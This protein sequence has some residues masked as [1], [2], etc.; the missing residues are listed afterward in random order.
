MKM[1]C[2][3]GHNDPFMCAPGVKA[4]ARSSP[5]SI[6]SWTTSGNRK[7]RHLCHRQ[8]RWAIR[9]VLH[10]YLG[11]EKDRFFELA[12]DNAAVSLLEKDAQEIRVSY[13]NKRL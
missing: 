9:S 13:M 12:V 7:Q 1:N 2:T 4:C 6:H 3:A 5:G 11:L 8:P 10:H